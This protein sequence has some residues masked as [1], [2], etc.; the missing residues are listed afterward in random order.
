MEEM[1]TRF[2]VSGFVYTL[3]W[4]GLV[5]LAFTV[6]TF[7]RKI[8]GWHVSTSL[9]TGSPWMSQIAPGFCGNPDAI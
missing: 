2:W 8:I 9:T 4:K 7:A 3:S 1:P 6:D 5:Y